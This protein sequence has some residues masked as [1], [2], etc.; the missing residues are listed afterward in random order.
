MFFFDS[1]MAFEEKFKIHAGI[2]YIIL[3]IFLGIIAS[4]FQLKYHPE[5][6]LVEFLF[7]SF[8]VSFIF[9]YY[10]IRIGNVYFIET[11]LLINIVCPIRSLLS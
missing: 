7:V 11:G 1:M 10:L 6:P 5:L 4:S 2:Y 3:S 9:N 8:F